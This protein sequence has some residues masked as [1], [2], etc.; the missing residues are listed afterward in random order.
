MMLA[1]M[2]DPVDDAKAHEENLTTVSK[3]V[4]RFASQFMRVYAN[5]NEPG[6]TV[7]Y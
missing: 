2:A 5:L 7:E 3:H 4:E 6:A 1:S